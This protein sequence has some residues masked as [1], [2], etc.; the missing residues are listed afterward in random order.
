MTTP[1]PQTRAPRSEDLAY[2]AAGLIDM[3]T[4]RVVGLMREVRGLLHRS[5]LR[6]IAR[7]GHADLLSRGELAFRRHSHV[8]ESHLE[9]LARRAAAQRGP[10]ADA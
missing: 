4:Y 3:A 9:T 2:A 1:S 7:D 10:D 5:D 6:V 8:P